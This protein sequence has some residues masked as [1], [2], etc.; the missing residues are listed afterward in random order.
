MIF[1]HRTYTFQTGQLGK[2]LK[3][4]EPEALHIQISHL[5]NLVGYF[6]SDIG[7]VIYVKIRIEVK[8]QK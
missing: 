5:G 8:S 6:T 1:D 4:Y 3:L 2:F 7:P